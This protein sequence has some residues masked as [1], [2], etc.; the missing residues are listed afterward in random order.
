ME[1]SCS[2]ETSVSAQKT[3][4]LITALKPS[5]LDVREDVEI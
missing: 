5:K 2:F 1:A 4:V 3:T